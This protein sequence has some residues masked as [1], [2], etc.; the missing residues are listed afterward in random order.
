[1]KRALQ[2]IVM[3][4]EHMRDITIDGTKKITIREGHRDYTLGSVLIGDDVLNW[5]TLKEITK[6]RHTTLRNV[7]PDEYKADECK[8]VEELKEMLSQFYPDIHFNTPVTVIY[9]C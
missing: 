3:A 6:V 7:T 8:S 4:T 2:G 9:F 1:M 5:A